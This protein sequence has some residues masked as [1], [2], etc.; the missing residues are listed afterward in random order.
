ML[1]REDMEADV[2][3]AHRILKESN[4]IWKHQN[5]SCDYYSKYGQICLLIISDLI[6]LNFYSNCVKHTHFSL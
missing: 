4:K 3:G 6:K 5:I 1:A 2:N